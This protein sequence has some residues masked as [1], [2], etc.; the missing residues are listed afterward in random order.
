MAIAGN[1]AGLTAAVAGFLLG[2]L[3]AFTTDVSLATAVVAGRCAFLGAVTGLVRRLATVK[4]ATASSLVLHYV[5]VG[6]S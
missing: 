2:G 3:G 6:R 1:V 4:A 5:E